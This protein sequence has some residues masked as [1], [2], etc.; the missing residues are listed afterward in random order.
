MFKISVSM[1]I[2]LYVFAAFPWLPCL[3]AK[4]VKTSYKRY[5][6]YQYNEHDVLCEPY[7]VSKDDWLYKIFRKK[8]EISEKDFPQFIIIFKKINPQIDNV[9]A[10]EPGIN[11]LIPL[12]KIKEEDY[13]QNSAGEIDIPVVEF[14]SMSNDLDLKPFLKKHTI[15]KG[16]TISKLIDKD[17]LKKGG[18]LSKEG[19]KAFQLANPDIKNINIIYEGADI[20]LPD[21]SIKSQS[22][23]NSL[24]SGKIPK[25]DAKKDKNRKNKFQSTQ[26]Q[27]ET[28]ELAQLKK[29]S[30]LIGGTLL[31][32]G[33]IYFPNK[34]GS[35]NVLD[36]SYSPVIE[37][38][39]GSKILII[40]GKNVNAEMLEYVQAYWKGIKT[41]LIS[42]TTKK[43]KD[44]IKNPNQN[45]N[46]QKHSVTKE[47]GKSIEILLNQTDYDY[48]SDTKI[49][50]T[51][52]NINLE[53]SFGRVI[54]PDDADLL[55]N[56]GN[57]YGSALNALEKREF[58]IFSLTP[59]MTTMEL[60]RQL[61]SHLGYETWENP[62]FS[63]KE[64]IQ[65]ITG[66]YA[67]KNQDKLFIYL[68]PLDKNAMDY[69]KKENI[70]PISTM[71]KS[72]I[73]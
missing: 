43:I 44:K 67:V 8:G 64:T 37:T 39:D 40:S 53:A 46:L 5:S 16:E 61:F 35:S 69:L 6:I 57:V 17:F 72:Q 18:A 15:Q 27:I 9:D 60:A 47:Y 21:P 59:E 32:Q 42:E 23:F 1:V 63:F 70:K 13:K 48:I 11:I 36:L 24:L 73:Q 30:A 56:F 52:S 14:S 10:I 7:V 20:Y 3:H 29:Y 2:T 50:F 65:T 31:N 55:I 38:K 41:Q 19:L 26:N 4:G 28:H 22:W 33:K 68:K 12:K 49:T 62:S 54:R 58:K 45:K 71:N 34:N 66:L 25:N 51:I